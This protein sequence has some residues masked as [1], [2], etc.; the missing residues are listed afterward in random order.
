MKSLFHLLILV[1][2]STVSSVVGM[3]NLY[4]QEENLES[5]LDLE[6]KGLIEDVDEVRRKW[7]ARSQERRASRFYEKGRVADALKLYNRSMSHYRV[8][9]DS[10]SVARIH[11]AMAEM[12]NETGNLDASRIHIEAASRASM[13]DSD[14]EVVVKIES[15]RVE[16]APS[17]QIVEA[18]EALPEIGGQAAARAK[19]RESYAASKDFQA[20]LTALRK[21][22]N[23]AKK[24]RVG[25]SLLQA[26]LINEKTNELASLAQAK[27]LQEMEAAQRMEKQKNR[28][29]ALLGVLVFVL[30]LAVLLWRLLITRRK[31]HTQVSGALKEL[32]TAHTQ[33]KSTQAQLVASEKMASIGQLTA[34]IAHEINNPVNY[35][36]GS[37]GPLRRDIEA[38]WEVL[39]AYKK[40]A[41]TTTDTQMLSQAQKLE[42]QEDLDFVKEEMEMLLAGMMEGTNRTA[43]IVSGLLDFSR[44]SD[45]KKEPFDL[46][47]QLDGTVSLLK[48][49]LSE[50]IKIVRVYDPT[51][52][53]VN[54]FPGKINQVFMNL[55]VNAMQATEKAQAEGGRVGK[56]EIKLCTEYQEELKQAI[57]TFEDQGTGI[58]EDVL[59]RLF[60]PFFTTKAVGE[61]TGLG[62]SISYGIIAEHSGSIEAKNLPEGGAL[63]TVTLPIA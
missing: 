52:P 26:I 55:M 38:V 59:P 1:F 11:T 28:Q 16:S 3:G 54:G 10:L 45:A 53:A 2:L 40:A 47:H 62:L 39:K 15:V 23:D 48:N 56:A 24:T 21:R 32:K 27:A 12:F 60:E 44:V 57:I 36:S 61:G 9:G 20:D 7:V 14:E 4:G 46:H 19:V 18:P 63:F 29:M 37:V 22:L 31:A 41:Q 13:T 35:I 51:M 58:A 8:L 42:A 6:E 33:L 43:E 49:Q 30:L 34:G 5:V 25:D 50:E 17:V